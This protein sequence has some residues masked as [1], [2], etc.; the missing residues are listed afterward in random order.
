MGALTGVRV[1]EL[2]SFIAGPF[3]T[4]MLAD[5]GAEVIKVER[6]ESGDP[7]RQWGMHF[8]DGESLWWPVIGRNKRSVAIDLKSERGKELVLA[9]LADSDVLVENFRPG[10][11][12]RLGFAPEELWCDNPGLVITR[13]SGFGQTGAYSARAGFG[14]VAEAVAGLRQLTGYP[15]RPPTRTGLSIADSLAG[16][17]AAFGTLAAL[18]V[19]ERS[20]KGQVVD[21]ALADSILAV[22]ES[23]IAEYSATGQVRERTGNIARIAPSNIYPT[24]DERHLVIGANADAPFSR[25]ALAMGRPE[26]AEDPRFE[27]HN[28]RADHHLELDEIIGQ[29][30]RRHT[31]EELDEILARNGVPAGP[32]NDAAGILENPHFRERGS[33]VKVETKLGELWMQGVAPRLSDTPGKVETSGQELGEDTAAVLSGLLGLDDEEIARLRL[34]GVVQTSAIQANDGRGTR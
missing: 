9:L 12:E 17:M 33:L 15:D 30:T 2:G 29:W 8:K 1:V 14:S 24:A 13:V 18:R 11:L 22:M 28:A 6:P 26:L 21:V 20:G 3:T 32:V 25:L 19:R 27:N 23:V 7:M 16:L 34:D 5:H 31:V 10:V 4:Q